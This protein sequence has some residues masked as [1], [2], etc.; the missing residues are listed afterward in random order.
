MELRFLSLCFLGCQVL[1]YFNYLCF[2]LRVFGL[3]RLSGSIRL[4]TYATN[5]AKLL[6]SIFWTSHLSNI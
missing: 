1:S 4:A 6:R 5:E 2:G 3:A